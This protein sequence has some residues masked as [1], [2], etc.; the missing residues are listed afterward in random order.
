MVALFNKP[1]WFRHS[2]QFFAALFRYFIV[3][4]CAGQTSLAFVLN[5]AQVLYKFLEMFK[6]EKNRFHRGVLYDARRLG[7]KSGIKRGGPRS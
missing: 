7:R 2:N 4:M 6:S 1:R 5:H 3:A